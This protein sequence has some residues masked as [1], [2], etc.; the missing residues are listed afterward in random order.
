MITAKSS[1]EY[2]GILNDVHLVCSSA[3]TYC[4]C[5]WPDPAPMKT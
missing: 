3:V 5:A 1:K 4:I 2:V